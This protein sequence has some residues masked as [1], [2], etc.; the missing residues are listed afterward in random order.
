M[1]RIEEL[2]LAEAAARAAGA[3]LRER[4][5]AGDHRVLSSEGHDVKL[6]V[7]LQSEEVILDRLR[8]ASPHPILSEEAGASGEFGDS[9]FWVVDPLDGSANYLRGIPFCCVSIALVHEE[10]A[11]VGAVYDFL[12]DEMFTAAAGAGAR[13]NAN[14]IAV[15][16]VTRS[17]DAVL[18]TGFPTHR[19]YSEQ[20]LSEYFDRVRSFKKVRM[21]GSAALMLA[22]VACGRADAYDEQD[23]LLWDVAGG[24]ALVGE[25]GGEALCEISPRRAWAR[26]V[27]CAASGKIW[28]AQ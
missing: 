8:S 2:E 1:E 12:R 18:F 5:A 10:R 25:A 11:E 21:L 23:T 3:F 14:P 28:E 15:S 7:D 27:R 22:Y 6:Q 20:S 24:L 13:L 4:Y 16:E 19:D 17:A 9:P 26:N